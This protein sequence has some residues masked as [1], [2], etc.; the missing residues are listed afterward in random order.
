V[1]EEGSTVPT[2]TPAEEI[3]ARAA[4]WFTARSDV[5]AASQSDQGE[6]EAWLAESA[7]NLLAYWRM[8]AGWERAG[9]LAAVRPMR[10]DRTPVRD[11]RPWGLWFGRVAAIAAIVGIGVTAAYQLSGDKTE[12]YATPVGGHRTVTLADG[13][14]IELNTNTVLR[15][16][17]AGQGRKVELAQG[18]AYFSVKHDRAH[19][20]IVRV[21]DHRLVDL[22]TKFVVRKGKDRMKVGLIEGS[23]RLED[24]DTWSRKRIAVLAA[25]DVAVA[26]PG[27]VL[28]TRGATRELA[29]DVA[30]RENRLVFDRATLADA[31][32][33]FNRY[34]EQKLVIPDSRVARLTFS[35]VFPIHGVEAF[36]RVAQKSLGLRVEH[37]GGEIV[38]SR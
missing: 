3:D 8:E 19:P 33:E 4:A 25:G 5:N 27:K 15:V 23:V 17:R 9:L 29:E 38:I 12:I 18:E 22:G 7:N 30:W 2:L 36:V 1:S 20:F 21:G 32:A 35:S 34:N 10:G 16:S 26:T 13:S 28:I 37:R 11:R 24:A 6:F 14:R 31:A